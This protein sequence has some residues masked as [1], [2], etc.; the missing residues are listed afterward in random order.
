MRK[1]KITQEQ[2]D[3]L[4]TANLTESTEVKGGINRVDKT[5]K[6]EFAG[7]DIKNLSEDNFDIKAPVAGIPNSKMKMKKEPASLDENIFSPEVHQAVSQLI[8]NIWLN[9]SQHGL[10][11]FFKQHG[12]TWGDITTYLTG[13]GVLGA[14]AGGVHKLVNFF[15]TKFNSNPEIA[16]E[17]KKEDIKKIV[18]KITKDPEAPWNKS[19]SENPE[20][21][22]LDTSV[23]V[24]NPDRFKPLTRT[25]DEEKA[26]LMHYLDPN[27]TGMP[28]KAEDPAYTN[29]SKSNDP[30]DLMPYLNP[31]NKGMPFKNTDETFDIK[32][33]SIGNYPAGAENNPLAPYNQSGPELEK[34]KAKQIFKPL[35]MNKDIILLNGPDSMY[36]FDYENL[37][38]NE[39][40]NPAYELNAEDL[41]QYVNENFKIL[42]KGVGLGAFNK[43][44]DLVK[45]DEHLRE[46]LAKIYNKDK[47]FVHLLN[48]VEEM[49]G[50]ASS[51]AFTGPLGGSSNG[52]KIDKNNTPAN[53][54]ISDEEEFLGGKKIDETTSAAGGT[55]QSSSSGQ[56]TQP[57]I[58][59][60]D[61]KNWAANKKTQYPNGEMVEFDP[62]TKLN[63]NKSAQNGKCSQG[64]A[65]NVVK[66]HKTKG[67]VISKSIYETI[68]KKTGKTVK[69]V[70]NIIETKVLKNKPL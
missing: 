3:R 42:S 46:Y 64:A 65:D 56:Y 47:E 26:A 18:D 52:P 40:P 37:D 25:S 7:S 69:E 10:D 55:P 24:Y 2:Y 63:N 45:M 1:V 8:H 16:K 44:V 49:T 41:T 4:F 11:P 54:L 28:F 27:N 43:G 51:G 19:Q 31:D 23:P 29:R 59:A 17:Q 32:T 66:T 15:K 34:S 36:V 60:K 33:S 35:G 38:R 50:A 62:C 6:R 61:K 39:L 22:K 14:A 58:W 70:K 30:K 9:P 67:S 5:F 68:A 21:A 57:A 12:I 48:R 20:E 13:V 53:A